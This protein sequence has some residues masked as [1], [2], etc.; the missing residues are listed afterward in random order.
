MKWYVVALSLALACFTKVNAQITLGSFGG[1]TPSLNTYAETQS[2][3]TTTDYIT[4]TINNIPFGTNIPAGW[5]FKVKANGNFTNG[6]SSIPSQYIALKF[7]SIDQGP[8]GVSG[9]AVPLTGTATQLTS[10]TTALTAPTTYY[11]A[12]RFNLIIQGG[13]HLLVPTT[14]TYST[15]L[16]LTLYNNVG[17]LIATNNNIPIS[18]TINFS[19]S[20]TGVALD[21]GTNNAFN[22]DTYAKIMAGGIVDD[23]VTLQYNPNA[24][25]CTGWSLK[26]RANG[27][28]TNG[29]SSISPQ[30]FSLRFD[31]V[32]NGSPTAAAIGVGTNAVPLSLTD[33]NLITNS[34]AAFQTYT[35]TEHKF[36]LLIQGG[37]HFLSNMVSGNY[38]TSL[39]FSLYNLSGQLVA[40]K[41]MPVNFQITYGNSFNATVT[42]LDPNAALVYDT[43]AK[44]ISGVSVSKAAGLKIIAYN[45]YQV[46]AKTVGPNFTSGSNTIPVSAVR[47]ENTKPAGKTGIV[48]TTIALASTDQQIITNSMP[49]FTYQTIEYNLRYYTLGN[50]LAITSAPSGN[51]TTQVIYL[52]LPL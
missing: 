10:T 21:G 45:G 5:H 48:S 12:Q 50:T 28:F 39:T 23:A 25:N 30:Y 6:T 18:F 32:S 15:T 47:L 34:N 20:C 7:N 9:G 17:A 52:V 2:G 11:V 16:T 29:S 36:D 22:F 33:A 8:G 13:S 4:L 44:Y 1:G 26:V 14:G 37:N 43:P 41:V 35:Y 42:L 38:T 49:D 3:S 27:N 51:Y 40:T 31:R 24:A 46:I 19:N